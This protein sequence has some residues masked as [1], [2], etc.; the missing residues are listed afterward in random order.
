MSDDSIQIPDQWKN[1]RVETWEGSILLF[2]PVDAGK[3]TFGRYLPK[4]QRPE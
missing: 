4:G 3:S 1:L 2:G